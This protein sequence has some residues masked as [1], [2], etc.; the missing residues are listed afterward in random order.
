[1]SGQSGSD[2]EEAAARKRHRI[3]NERKKGIIFH[4]DKI[5]Y[6]LYAGRKDL[7]W[8]LIPGAIM[9]GES[10]LSHAVSNCNAVLDLSLRRMKQVKKRSLRVMWRLADSRYQLPPRKETGCEGG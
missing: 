2:L 8:S 9:E 1:M 3:T 5:L 10:P 7:K 6:L 4:L